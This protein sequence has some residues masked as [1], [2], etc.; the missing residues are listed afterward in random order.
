MCRRRRQG[1]GT[2]GALSLPHLVELCR[3]VDSVK[4]FRV[5]PLSLGNLEG[6][7]EEESHNGEQSPPPKTIQE[8]GHLIPHFLFG[9]AVLVSDTLG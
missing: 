9:D 6:E 8:Q 2:F 3:F 4:V 7:K 5:L 1:G